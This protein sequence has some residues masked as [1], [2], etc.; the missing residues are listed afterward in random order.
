MGGRRNLGGFV[1]Q[2]RVGGFQ[3]EIRE[4]SRKVILDT[5]V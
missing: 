2:L 1:Q 3:I 5:L 4:A